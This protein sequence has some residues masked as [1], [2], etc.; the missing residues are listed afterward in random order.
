MRRRYHLGGFGV[1]AG[2][3][4]YISGR[5]VDSTG[6]VVSNVAVSAVQVA[7]NFTFKATTNADGLYRIPSL[8]PGAYRITFEAAGF[9]KLL[10]DDVDLRAGDNLA[11]DVE[12][13]V[14]NVTESIEVQGT[15]TLLET[16][17]SAAGSL[18]EGEVL[19]KLPLYQRYV[20]TTLNLV[21]GMTMGGY[22]YGGD[23]GAFHIA[24]QRNSTIGLFED[25][26]NANEQMSG[27]VGIKPVQNS[28]EEVKVLTTTLPA[29]YGHSAGGVLAVV[30]KSGTNEFHGL[31]AGYG[32][33]RRM[34]HRL[35]FDRLRTSDPQPGNPNGVP[36]W[37]MD[38]E[39]NAS[40][41]VVIPKL[42]NGR[43][44]TFFFFGYQKLIEKKAAQVLVNTPTD[45][46]KA[47]DVSY[48]G[49]GQPIYDPATTRQNPDGTWTRDPFPTKI[50]PAS[51][52]DPVA[53]KILSINPWVPPNAAG[54]FSPT[55]PVTNLI[56]NENSRTFFED[57]SEPVKDAGMVF[58]QPRALPG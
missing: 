20:N 38:P 45:A 25:G 7:T 18:M 58:G 13:Q 14:G 34:Q 3:F 47:G 57:Y 6:A 42:Y 43:N 9:K 4:V 35:F 16:E 44:R 5:V 39:A 36:T 23:F 28:V 26:V 30:K 2:G 27:T 15:T 50:V 17:T 8:Q 52:F 19:H 29:E 41:P 37:F 51:R 40:G 12:L 24:G 31:A 49:M 10:R 48:G 54:A 55:G 11:V 53:S 21:P 1:G 33:T 32:R 22:G 46:M 56:T